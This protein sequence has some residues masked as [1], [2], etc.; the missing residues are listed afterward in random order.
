MLLLHLPGSAQANEYT[1]YCDSHETTRASE[2]GCQINASTW[3]CNACWKKGLLT[4]GAWKRKHE[5]PPAQNIASE[6]STRVR[7]KL[8]DA[9]RSAWELGVPLERTHS[10]GK[11]RL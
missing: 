6:T 2:G 8:L 9:T 11:T 4:K 7:D 10:D 3:I 5:Q 1:R